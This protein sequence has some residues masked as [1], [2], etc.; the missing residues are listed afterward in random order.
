MLVDETALVA[1]TGEQQDSEAD[2]EHL[3]YSNS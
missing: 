2:D 1:V 3:I